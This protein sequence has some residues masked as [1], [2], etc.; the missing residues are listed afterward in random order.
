MAFWSC[1]VNTHTHSPVLN[2]LASNHKCLL[3]PAKWMFWT[4]IHHF[5]EIFAKCI[6]L[7][8][9]LRSVLLC[10]YKCAYY[11]R[12]AF[13]TIELLHLQWNYFIILIIIISF[14]RSELIHKSNV[15]LFCPFIILN[16]IRNVMLMIII[17]LLIIAMNIYIEV[18]S[19]MFWFN[20]S[21][22]SIQMK[23]SI[24]SK[25]KWNRNFGKF[26]F[27]S[28]FVWVLFSTLFHLWLWPLY[29]KLFLLR[30]WLVN[31]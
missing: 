22:I 19:I 26:Q 5:N 18:T 6:F 29:W 27:F 31:L 11:I 17:V 2:L 9:N 4:K 20:F 23:L 14:N 13:H 21:Q 24:K 16:A 3:I 1:S 25:Q 7:S 10:E 12:N 8:L 15:S 30:M 28:I